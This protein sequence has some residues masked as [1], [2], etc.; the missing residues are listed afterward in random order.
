MFTEPSGGI[1]SLWGCG[2]SLGEFGH[3]G[4][5]VTLWGNSVTL[6]VTLV[7]RVTVPIN[8]AG[9]GQSGLLGFCAAQ[10]FDAQQADV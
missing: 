5:V 10:G 8:R 4:G 9:G 1:W 3:S 2:H 6:V 7:V